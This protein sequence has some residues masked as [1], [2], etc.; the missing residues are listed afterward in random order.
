MSLEMQLVIESFVHELT[1]S[2]PGPILAELEGTLM[3]VVLTMIFPVNNTRMY[4]GN[5]QQLNGSR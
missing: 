1:T 4:P 3:M 2:N 5:W